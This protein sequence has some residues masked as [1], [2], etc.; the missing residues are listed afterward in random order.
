MRP[1]PTSHRS[2]RRH[3]RRLR[4][5]RQNKPI[6]TKSESD[7]PERMAKRLV[8]KGWDY[9]FGRWRPPGYRG[10][11]EARAKG[12]TSDFAKDIIAENRQEVR[13]AIR[14]GHI[15]DLTGRRKKRKSTKRRNS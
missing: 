15:I 4:L 10:Y 1:A 12:G 7:L 8:R 13:R 14:Q 9:G 11:A 2:H 5:E 3:Q 6:P